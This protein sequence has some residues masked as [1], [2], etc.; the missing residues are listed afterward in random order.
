MHVIITT[1]L[2]HTLHDL[3]HAC[4]VMIFHEKEAAEFPREAVRKFAYKPMFKAYMANFTVRPR[5]LLIDWLWGSHSSDYEEFYLLDTM[6][7]SH[8]TGNRHSIG[9]FHLHLQDR[10]NQAKDE[11]EVG[12]MQSRYDMQRFFT[13]FTRIHTQNILL[14]PQEA[15]Q[16]MV[17][18][19]ATKGFSSPPPAV[20]TS[21]G[22]KC[23]SLGK[24]G[25]INILSN[26]HARRTE[27]QRR[28][29][30]NSPME[31]WSGLKH[32]ENWRRGKSVWQL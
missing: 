15:V 27:E 29:K 12:N 2:F 3:L 1:E 11:H 20:L 8:V 26:R 5:V 23:L 28:G 4:C 19:M 7:C 17:G 21:S 9:T 22:Q 16:W 32:L 24:V 31:I 25:T 10:L 30:P 14:R 6:T 13:M 18:D